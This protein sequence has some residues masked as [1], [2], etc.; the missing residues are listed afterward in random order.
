MTPAPCMRYSSH[1]QIS[2]M[3]GLSHPNIIALHELIEEDKWVYIIEEY[4]E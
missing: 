1:N 2:M 4:C 3:K